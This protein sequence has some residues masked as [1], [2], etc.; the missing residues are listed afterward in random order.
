MFDHFQ[1]CFFRPTYTLSIW[2]TDRGNPP[3]SSYAQLEIEVTD[4]NDNAPMFSLSSYRAV[5]RENTLRG[6]SFFKASYR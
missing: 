4:E 6:T 2:V 5:A 1:I 3:L